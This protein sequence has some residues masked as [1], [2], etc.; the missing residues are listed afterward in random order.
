MVATPLDGKKLSADLQATVARQVEHLKKTTGQTPGLAVLLVGDDPASQVYV[1]KKGKTAQALGLYSTVIRLPADTSLDTVL[2]TLD[3]LNVDERIHGILVQLPLP[4]HLDSQAVLTRVNP[5]KDVDGF[6]PHNLGRLL[7]GD[8]PAALPCTPAGMMALLKAYGIQ[9]SGKHAVVVGRSVI[10]GKPI[11]L[12]LLQAN[13]TVTLCHSRT[14]NLTE[15]MRQADILVAAVGK[16]EM[17]TGEDIK[18]GAV[19]LDVGINRLPDGRLVG[20]VDYASAQNV[21][22]Y[23]TPVPGG[24]GPMTIAT[25]MMNTIALFCEQMGCEQMDCT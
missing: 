21:A 19:V 9:P 1:G 2:S 4:A 15:H 5:R 8:L 13:A 11:A 10:V 14:P 18:P 23:L 25:L 3:E 22:A 12:L 17:I 7:A 24:V 6:H 16:P 20:D